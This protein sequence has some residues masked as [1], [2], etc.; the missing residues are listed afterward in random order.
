MIKVKL[1]TIIEAIKAG[2]P[3]SGMPES[4]ASGAES[5]CQVVARNIASDL[6]R[7]NRDF[8]TER[9][10]VACGVDPNTFSE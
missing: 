8:D 9:F 1:E 7:Y 10:L 5:A 6:V 3:A 2:R 4:W